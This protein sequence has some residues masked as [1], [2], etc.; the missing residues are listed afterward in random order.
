MSIITKIM[1]ANQPMRQVY[2]MNRSPN[3]QRLTDP[4]P[5]PAGASR[6][7]NPRS[8]SQQVRSNWRQ[9]VQSLGQRI[10]GRAGR[11]ESDSQA[12][13]TGGQRQPTLSAQNVASGSD[14]SGAE[15]TN[16]ERSGDTGT[17][18]EGPPGNLP[19]ET[20]QSQSGEYD[21]PL[22]QIFEV[23]KNSR[24]RQTLRFLK[25]NDGETTLSEVAEHI[26]ALENDTT[27]RAITSAQ[28]KR[29]YIG[30]YQCHLPKMDD[31][32]VIDFEQNRGTI[33]LGPNAEQL[34]PYLDGAADR[35][36]YKMYLGVA[37]VGTALFVGQLLV[38]PAM[39]LFST[40][41]L[42]GLL[43]GITLTAVAHSMA[44]RE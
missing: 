3:H 26:A 10:P 34:E 31:M 27:P 32:N 44:T 18:D 25:E 1:F 39:G 2:H 5:T 15:Q 40:A 43:A 38:G 12:R 19:L 17:T 11:R 28:R 21:L 36:W 9:D 6:A 29:V 7:D 8:K 14:P 35:D 23:L 24:R 22:D 33:E 4:R 42:V 41:I 20:G 30:L 37:L 16:T 13:A